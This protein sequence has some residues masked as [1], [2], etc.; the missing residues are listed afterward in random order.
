MS[1]TIVK[2]LHFNWHVH[3]VNTLIG[4]FIGLTL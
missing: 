2:G 1:I 4:M 3:R